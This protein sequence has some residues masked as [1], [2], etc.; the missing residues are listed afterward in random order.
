MSSC[1]STPAGNIEKSVGEDL[2]SVSDKVQ[3]ALDEAIER[4]NSSTRFFDL[5]SEKMIKW[6]DKVAQKEQKIKENCDQIEDMKEFL[7]ED[8][9]DKCG[10]GNVIK[11]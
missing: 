8:C 1:L 6:E 4:V 2:L 5:A 10:E 9:V 7:D 11:L 3:E